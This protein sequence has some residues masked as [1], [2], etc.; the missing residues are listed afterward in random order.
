MDLN[1]QKILQY[2]LDESSR[3]S[4]LKKASAVEIDSEK[5]ECLSRWMEK[6]GVMGFSQNMDHYPFKLRQVKY[7]PYIVY[8]IGNIDLLSQSML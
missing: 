1:Q 2:S 7:A 8:A 6:A 4:Q 3:L 5:A